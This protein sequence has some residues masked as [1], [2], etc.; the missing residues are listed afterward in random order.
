MTTINRKLAYLFSDANLFADAKNYI[1]E[2]CLLNHFSAALNGNNAKAVTLLLE[3]LIQGHL[4]ALTA[5]DSLKALWVSAGFKPEHLTPG[6]LAITATGRGFGFSKSKLPISTGKVG[7]D[8]ALAVKAYIWDTIGNGA[9][10]L[11]ER[12]AVALKVATVAATVAKEPAT[13]PTKA[14]PTRKP[15]K[16]KPAKAT[17]EVAAP[18]A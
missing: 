14:K 12:E 2:D 16:V 9:R 3:N 7:S 8:A 1:A 17:V 18:A 5:D 11:N 4:T 15:A 6:T 10:H 13:K